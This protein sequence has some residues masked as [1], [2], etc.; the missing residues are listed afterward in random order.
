MKKRRDKATQKRKK[1]KKEASNRHNKKI[2]KER[3]LRDEPAR[4]DAN[5]KRLVRTGGR[6]CL[7]EG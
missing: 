3:K 7:K 2:L 6:A 4:G 1:K 5:P